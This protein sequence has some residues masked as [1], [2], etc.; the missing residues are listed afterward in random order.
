MPNR[1]NR[2]VALGF[3]VSAFFLRA[4]G[5][6]HADYDELSPPGARSNAMGGAI[7]SDA[8]DVSIVFINPAGLMALQKN[9]I[10]FA[11]RGMTEAATIGETIAVVFNVGEST[12]YALSLSAEQR[13]EFRMSDGEEILA[14]NIAFDAGQAVQLMPSVSF[15][16]HIGLRHADAPGFQFIRLAATLGLHYSPSPEINYAAT[17]RNAGV[18]VATR[19]YRTSR[20]I[21]PV[22][23]EVGLSMRFPS[24][25]TKPRVT[26]GLAN[27]KIFGIRGVAYKIGIEYSMADFLPLRLGYF[28]GPIRKGF[29]YGVGIRLGAVQIDYAVVAMTRR[30]YQLSA[31]LEL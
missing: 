14:H 24:S 11:H 28:A 6:S 5:Q 8:R 3:L 15:G 21:L 9:S 2:F 4:A 29:S 12:R 30:T 18:D 25:Y 7:V 10:L 13:G 19:N 16:T 20:S 17:L 1:A 23:L 22:G 26:I 31:L 27:E